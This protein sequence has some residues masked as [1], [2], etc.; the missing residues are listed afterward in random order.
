MTYTYTMANIVIVPVH[1]DKIPEEREFGQMVF[2]QDYSIDTDP[3]IKEIAELY[4]KD[5][6]HKHV[7]LFKSMHK[8]SKFLFEQGTIIDKCVITVRRKKTKEE[9]AWQVVKEVMPEIAGIVESSED[10]HRQDSRSPSQS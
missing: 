7:R 10:E 2:V 9:L 3:D 1:I 5:I 4:C 6:D 8:A